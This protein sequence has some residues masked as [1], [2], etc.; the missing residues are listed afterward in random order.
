MNLVLCKSLSP[1]SSKHNKACPP[2]LFS[3]P[4]SRLSALLTVMLWLIRRWS[5]LISLNMFAV[6]SKIEKCIYYRA[7]IHMHLWHTLARLLLLMSSTAHLYFIWV[8]YSRHTHT[9]MFPGYMLDWSE[10]LS[11]AKLSRINE[12]CIYKA[13]YCVLLYTQSSLQSCGGGG[14]LSLTTIS[15]QH[16]FGCSP[17]TS[18]RWRAERVIESI[19]CMHSPHTSYRWRAERVIESIKWMGIIRRPWLTRAQFNI[20]FERWCFLTI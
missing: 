15:V 7:N 12:W 9:V 13:L 5:P 8:W 16:P 6:Y 1:L 4:W 17:H 20:S 18:Y 10:L 19:K 14:G 2:Q 3:K 11:L